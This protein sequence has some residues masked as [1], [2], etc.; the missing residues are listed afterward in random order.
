MK[1]FNDQIDW[2]K[3]INTK[4][5]VHNFQMRDLSNLYSNRV[6]NSVVS[7]YA[8]GIEFSNDKKDFIKYEFGISKLGRSKSEQ[9]SCK[10]MHL[11]YG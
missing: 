1:N 2:F 10:V 4:S 7:P 8:L 11:T 3:K 9:Y 6:Y 5:P